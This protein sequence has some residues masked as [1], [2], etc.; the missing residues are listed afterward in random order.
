MQ[1]EIV[2]NELSFAPTAPDIPSAR[3]RMSLFI[4]V[5]RD[6]VAAGTSRVLRTDGPLGNHPLAPGYPVA[7]WRNDPQV[8]RDERLYFASLT[9][10]APLLCDAPDAAKKEWLFEGYVQGDARPWRSGVAAYLLSALLVSL[11][12]H[13]TW[14]APWLTLRFLELRGHD[15]WVEDEVRLPHASVPEHLHEHSEWIRDQARICVSEG[16]EL[17]HRRG[18]LFPDLD[19]CPA[20]EPQLASLRRGDRALGSV[21]KRLTELQGYSRN[22]TAGPF[23]PRAL[24]GDARVDSQVTLDQYREERT[25]LC[26]DG[27]RRCFSWHLSVPLGGWRLYFEPL[28]ES[29]RIMIGYVG[30]HLRTA[31]FG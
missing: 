17:W 29:R 7:Q 10:K 14:D 5:V 12:G 15:E 8:D 3:A 25:F 9:S 30:P 2:L 4:R 26:P 21:L 11:S 13:S 20:V 16:A 18:E 23:D 31:R 24:P 28:P 1:P 19:F 27:T 6:A 22:W